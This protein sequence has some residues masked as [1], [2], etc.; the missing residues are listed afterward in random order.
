MIPIFEQ[1]KGK[2][3]GHSFE[4]FIEQFNTICRRYLAEKRVRAFAFIFYDF[5]DSALRRILKDLGVF[6]KLDRLSGTEL[7]IFYLHVEPHVHNPRARD[8]S[9]HAIDKFNEHFLGALGVTEQVGLPCIVFFRVR[10]DEINDIEVVQLE[11]GN[12]VHGFQE[13]YSAVE[14]YLAA[15]PVAPASGPIALKWIKSGSKF[16][17]LQ[18]FS[19]ALG[20][21]FAGLV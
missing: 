1:G 20:R 8:K 6:A 16:V 14:R 12:L 7:S 18:M 2:G 17:G 10:D 5:Q 15:S 21:V 11:S 9:R 19:A 4:S 3:I 13:L